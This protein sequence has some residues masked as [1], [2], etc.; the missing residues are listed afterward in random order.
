MAPPL[1]PPPPCR[2]GSRLMGKLS[3]NETGVTYLEK[4]WK[5]RKVHFALR[6]LECLHP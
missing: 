2:Q 6:Q 3:R 5:T 1:P 4:Q